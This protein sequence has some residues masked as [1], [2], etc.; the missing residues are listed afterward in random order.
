MCPRA[1][2]L[3]RSSACFLK[4]KSSWV[5]W[6]WFNISSPK[7]ICLELNYVKFN[8][9]REYS[10]DCKNWKHFS[11]YRIWRDRF[12]QAYDSV[13]RLWHCLN[14]QWKLHCQLFIVKSRHPDLSLPTVSTPTGKDSSS[15]CCMNC[16]EGRTR[17]CPLHSDF[18]QDPYKLNQ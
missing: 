16:T 17:I 15:I 1:G 7:M 2:L 4:I 14:Q 10:L 3:A 13:M 12:P 11:S 5:H 18:I 8:K 9:S 6:D